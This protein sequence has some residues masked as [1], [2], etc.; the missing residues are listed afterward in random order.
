MEAQDVV[1]EED[2][3][4][5]VKTDGEIA[6]WKRHYENA[7][8][9]QNYL[10]QELNDNVEVRGIK[11]VV[12]SLTSIGMV[13]DDLEQVRGL[14]GVCHRWVKVVTKLLPK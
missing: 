4:V 10:L 1:S 9:F 3:E 14:H 8:I 13:K 5:V 2:V 6:M 12:D 11:H 7:D